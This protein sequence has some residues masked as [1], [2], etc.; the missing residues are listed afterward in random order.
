MSTRRF[1]L[2]FAIILIVIGLAGFVPPLLDPAQGGEIAPGAHHDLLL[3]IF[4]VNPIA[5]VLHLLCG[6]WGAWASRGSL[7][8][9]GY[10]RGIAIIFAVLTLFGCIPGL[11]DLFGLLPLYGNDL[12]L[13][14]GTAAVAAYFGWVNRTSATG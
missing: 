2:V 11:D 7:K 13:H 4:P 6:A 12:W 10:A 14:F 1:A 8:A 9:L 3:G 5:N